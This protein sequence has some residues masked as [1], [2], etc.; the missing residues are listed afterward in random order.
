MKTSAHT[1]VAKWFFLLV[2]L[3]VLY[4]AWKIISP[5]AAALVTAAVF[6]VV[7]TPFHHLVM[8]TITS[9]RKLSALVVLALFTLG[10]L[11][12]LAVL[13]GLVTDQALS[14][15]KSISENGVNL[16][17]NIT[18]EQIPFYQALPATVQ[19]QLHA[20]D[21][22]TAALSLVQKVGSIG[23]GAAVSGVLAVGQFL[24]SLFLF[25][26]GLYYFLVKRGE[27]YDFLLSM[28]PFENGLD[29][30]IIHR[31]SST[32]RRVMMGA[33]IVAAVQGLL[34]AIGMTIAGVPGAFLWG[35]VTIVMAQIPMIGP[36]LVMGPAIIYLAAT[37][38][39]VAALF[40]LVWGI[41]AVGFVDNLMTPMLIG[42]G[43]KMPELLILIFILG[44][45]QVFGAI[46]FILGPTIL[47]ALIVVV[48]IYQ[49]GFLEGK[50]VRGI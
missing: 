46:G 48:E 19:T 14:L 49:A 34:A 5:F 25:Y 36:G 29:K 27:I 12:P 50:R 9:S 3:V 8:R 40:L 39:P 43:G 28:S 7:L 41:V 42:A 31:L 16:E 33:V 10:V 17:F 20:F 23:A 13:G 44:G 6:S 4:F 32:V 47:A 21:I 35:A 37:G 1:H 45:L 2:A 11:I 38:N 26:L 15:A 30:E 24:F 22:N 18:P